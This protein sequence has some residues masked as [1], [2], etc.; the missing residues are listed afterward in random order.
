MTAADIRTSRA[1]PL[2]ERLAAI[3]D[4]VT[5]LIAK[6]HP[7]TIVLE[8]VFTHHTYVST[9]AKMAHARGVICLAAQEHGVTLA[10]YAPALVKKSITGTGAASKDQVARMVGQWL[11]RADPAWSSDATD[12]LALAIVHAHVM[13]HHRN[14]P[15]GTTR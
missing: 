5:G 3:H 6:F 4:A 1:W 11:H 13:N 7:G 9:A 2:A 12:A 14:L 10:E 8:Q 15:V